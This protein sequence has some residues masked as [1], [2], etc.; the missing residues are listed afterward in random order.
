MN[1]RSKQL[2]TALRF[3]KRNSEVNRMFKCKLCEVRSVCQVL[4]ALNNEN[5]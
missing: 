3:R 5:Y 4:R 1:T 2:P